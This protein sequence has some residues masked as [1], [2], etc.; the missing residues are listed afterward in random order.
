MAKL[1]NLKEQKKLLDTKLTIDLTEWK[2]DYIIEYGLTGEVVQ[3]LKEIEQEEVAFFASEFKIELDPNNPQ[4]SINK[5]MKNLGQGKSIKM[6]TKLMNEFKKE[7]KFFYK[8]PGTPEKKDFMEF[9]IDSFDDEKI[10]E[11]YHDDFVKEI[12]SEV[13]DAMG[14]YKVG[15]K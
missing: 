9:L 4:K 12:Y 3:I 7:E 6:I 8:I 14:K 2:K 5:I 13:M 1:A 11:N 10:A 15:K